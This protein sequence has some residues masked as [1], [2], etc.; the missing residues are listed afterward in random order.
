MTFGN[1]IWDYQ[2]LAE[3]D[4]YVFFRFA[5][6]TCKHRVDYVIYVDYVDNIDKSGDEN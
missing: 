4:V 6:S 5:Y 1:Q 2:L 3:M